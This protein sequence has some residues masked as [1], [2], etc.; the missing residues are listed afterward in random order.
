MKTKFEPLKA[1]KKAFRTC[2]NKGFHLKFNNGW[3]V[4][5]QFGPG[6]YGDNYDRIS[7]GFDTEGL[8]ILKEKPDMESDEVEVLAWCGKKQIPKEPLGY[9]NIN[10]VMKFINKI[11]KKKKV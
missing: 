9:Q 2:D 6:N 8:D 4:S 11:R 5:I 10:E 3:I 1:T 7:E